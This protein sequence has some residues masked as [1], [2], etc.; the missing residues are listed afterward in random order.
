M[1]DRSLMHRV[2]MALECVGG[3]G[4]REDILLNEIALDSPRHVEASAVREHLAEAKRRGWVN[5]SEGLLGE[6]RWK[7]TANGEQASRDLAP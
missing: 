6:R 4:A 1:V 5:D 3:S 7:I 2:L